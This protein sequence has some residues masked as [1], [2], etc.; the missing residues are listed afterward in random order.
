M[1]GLRRS[2]ALQAAFG[3][4]VCATRFKYFQAE[5][6]LPTE[7]QYC[8]HIDSFPHLIRCV[9]IGKPPTAPDALVEYLIGLA[10]RANNINPGMPRPVREGWC[11]EMDLW[12]PDN[13][14]SELPDNLVLEM[15]DDALSRFDDEQFQRA[16]PEREPPTVELG[17]LIAA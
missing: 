6:L 1:K 4:S 5:R 11:I 13:E 10:G 16:L 7:C 12:P 3:S 14:E 9:N 2:R 17:E 15:Q 8:G